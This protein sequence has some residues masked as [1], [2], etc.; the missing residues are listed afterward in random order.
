[1]IDFADDR[2]G[3]DAV[4]SVLRVALL[5]PWSVQLRR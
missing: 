5:R 2:A 1:M 3:K 4:D